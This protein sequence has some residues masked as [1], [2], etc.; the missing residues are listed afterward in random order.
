[1]QSQLL[2]ICK[3]NLPLFHPSFLLAYHNPLLGFHCLAKWH[4]LDFQL[5]RK[6]ILREILG[7]SRLWADRDDCTSGDV[8]TNLKLLRNV[9]DVTPK[10][11]KKK[12]VIGLFSNWVKQGETVVKCELGVQLSA[13]SYKGRYFT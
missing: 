8:H 1:M 4:G 11:K 9:Y 2:I 3:V 7:M 6:L 13:H 12:T 5:K 10:L